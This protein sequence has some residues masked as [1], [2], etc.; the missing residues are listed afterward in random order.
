MI[1][2]ATFEAAARLARGEVLHRS[3]VT[4]G[5][6]KVIDWRT[7]KSGEELMTDGDAFDVAYLFVSLVGDPSPKEKTAFGVAWV[8]PPDPDGCW[9]AGEGW[10]L[11]DG[12][13]RWTGSREEA[14]DKARRYQGSSSTGCRYFVEPSEE[15]A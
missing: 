2:E 3:D 7:V 13:T 4:A 6:G 10:I 12:R 8:Q 5:N 11:R 14:E 15:F 1:Y 9:R